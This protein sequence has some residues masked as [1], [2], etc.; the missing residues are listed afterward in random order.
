[1]IGTS[2]CKAVS[3]L[4]LEVLS[5]TAKWSLPNKGK[6]EQE[7]CTLRLQQDGDSRNPHEKGRF[8]NG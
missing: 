6:A 8:G 1:M 2:I 7:C 5:S 3:G 4:V